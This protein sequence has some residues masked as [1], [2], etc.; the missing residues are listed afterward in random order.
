MSVVSIVIGGG[1]LAN[2]L[3]APLRSFDANRRLARRRREIHGWLLDA[4]E[5]RLSAHE[6]DSPTNSMSRGEPAPSECGYTSDRE[7]R[8]RD[9][10]L[11]PRPLASDGLNRILGSHDR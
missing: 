1:M 2:P 9:R 6:R 11:E 10:S 3:G 8:M 7:R 5:R 4:C